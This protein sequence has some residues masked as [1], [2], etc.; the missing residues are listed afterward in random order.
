MIKNSPIALYIAL[1]N[2]PNMISALKSFHFI[3]KYWLY[4]DTKCFHRFFF[5]LRNKKYLEIW[6]LI[7]SKHN[8]KVVSVSGLVAVLYC[9]FC[10][11][12]HCCLESGENKRHQQ[13]TKHQGYITRLVLP[14]LLSTYLV[15]S[16]CCFLD[17]RDSWLAFWPKILLWH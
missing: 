10:T 7:N 3:L 14:L 5:I 2:R 11:A 8:E 6:I 12:G 13:S 17:A 9:T 4:F 1:R 16:P 15:L